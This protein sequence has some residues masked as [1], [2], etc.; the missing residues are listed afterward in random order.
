MEFVHLFSSLYSKVTLV[1][2]RQQVLPRRDPEVAAILEQNF[3]RQGRASLLK[4]AKARAVD[5]TD[6]GVIASCDDCRTVHGSP[7]SCWRSDRS[8]TPMGSTSS[9]PA[10]TF[11]PNG[12]IPINHSLSV[13]CAEHLCG[14]GR[15][16]QSCR[17][18]RWQSMQGPQVGRARRWGCTRSSIAISITTR[19]RRRSSPNPEIAEVGLAEAE[20]FAMGRKLRVTKVPFDRRRLRRSSTTTRAAL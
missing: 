5:I 20:A 1:V 16:R 11:D 14:R 8:P 4:G 2:S 6:D 7:T 9:R 15:E 18:R 10:S 3:L 19:P 17:C 12:Y 13:E